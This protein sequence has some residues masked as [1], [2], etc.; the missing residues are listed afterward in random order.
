MPIIAMRGTNVLKQIT[1]ISKDLSVLKG[2]LPEALMIGRIEFSL[3]PDG[4]PR[5]ISWDKRQRAIRGESYYHVVFNEGY[6]VRS[7]MLA[8]VKVGTRPSR[9]TDD[10]C[11]GQSITPSEILEFVKTIGD[12]NPIHRCNYP[13]VP[14][15]M[16]LE[17]LLVESKDFIETGRY[18]FAV[19]KFISPLYSGECYRIIGNT[20]MNMKTD[21][22]VAHLVLEEE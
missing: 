1:Y 4:N 12:V 15:L 20:M 2:E 22:P 9:L 5:K 8:P 16:I 11:E 14:G 18:R 13:V 21:E 17:R 3:L 7:L 6:A 19:I 10:I